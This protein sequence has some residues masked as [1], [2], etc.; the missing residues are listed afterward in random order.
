LFWVVNK[1]KIGKVARKKGGSHWAIILPSARKGGKREVAGGTKKPTD[2][3]ETKRDSTL[4]NA[5]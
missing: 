2:E 5:V 1:E 4:L 3:K